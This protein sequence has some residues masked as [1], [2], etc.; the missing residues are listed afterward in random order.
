MTASEAARISQG[1]TWL[2]LWNYLA[3]LVLSLTFAGLTV[4]SPEINGTAAYA[5][6]RIVMAI[7]YSLVA[8]T[9]LLIALKMTGRSNAALKLAAEL[10]G[11]DAAA[12]AAAQGGLFRPMSALWPLF[13]MT[14]IIIVVNYIIL[15]YAVDRGLF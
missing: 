14:A 15:I 8:V 4:L 11:T 9:L 2:S 7:G 10:I 3:F 12:E 5:D 13:F 1:F 6:M